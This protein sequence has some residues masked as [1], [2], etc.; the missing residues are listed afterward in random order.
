MRFYNY[1]NALLA[2]Q[3]EDAESIEITDTGCDLKTIEKTGICEKFQ[4]QFSISDKFLIMKSSYFSFWINKFKSLKNENWKYWFYSTDIKTYCSRIGGDSHDMFWVTYILAP[5]EYTEWGSKENF[6]KARYIPDPTEADY[7]KTIEVGQEVYDN[8]EN[9]RYDFLVY[10][11]TRTLLAHKLNLK[12]ISWS[13]DAR[14]L[15]ESTPEVEIIIKGPNSPAIKKIRYFSDHYHPDELDFVVTEIDEEKDKL[16]F[17]NT[18]GFIARKMGVPFEI[19]LALKGD[20]SRIYRF[21]K[22]LEKALQKKDVDLNK[23]LNGSRKEISEEMKRLCIKVYAGPYRLNKY[24][25][26]CFK[27]GV[28][29]T[30]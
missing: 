20:K 12:R 10:Q 25:Y 3:N 9:Y 1:D 5:W 30:K 29:I 26:N 19:S 27:K 6:D 14:T 7:T 4:Y 16:I 24:V 15:L 23:I 13:A 2:I 11:F 18:C 22:S 17:A 28:I 21:K 8:I